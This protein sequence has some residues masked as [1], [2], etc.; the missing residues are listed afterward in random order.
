MFAVSTMSGSPFPDLEQATQFFVEG[1]DAVHVY[2]II[3]APPGGEWI[4]QGL[5]VP[6]G[7]MV[8]TKCRDR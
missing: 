3:D 7:T 8:S 6:E 1:L 2:D 5:G 4:E